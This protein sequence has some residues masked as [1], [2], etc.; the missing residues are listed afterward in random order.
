[1]KPP[2]CSTN[3]YADAGTTDNLEYPI[4]IEGIEP[5]RTIN[6]VRHIDDQGITCV[7]NCSLSVS[8]PSCN[9]VCML[10]PDFQF[11]VYFKTGNCQTRIETD[12]IIIETSGYKTNTIKL[13]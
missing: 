6:I 7:N 1:M 2:F 13:L 12:T 3:V 11:L 10:R 9:V 5:P 8:T 4:V